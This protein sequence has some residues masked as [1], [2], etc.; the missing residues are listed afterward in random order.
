MSGFDTFP[1]V[2]TALSF[3]ISGLLL[4]W[5]LFFS[6]RWRGWFVPATLAVLFF[7]RLPS[8]V[9]NREINPDESQMITQ[10]LT[11]GQYDPV[12]FRSVDGTTGGPLDSY[13]LVLPS[14]LG[15]PFD[16]I[17][18][19]LMA[20]LLIAVCLWFLYKTAQ[21]WFGEQP[22]RL[23]LL[24]VVFTLGFTQNADFLHYNSELIAVT[25]LSAAYFLYA[26]QTTTSMPPLTRLLFA[27]GFLLGMV[28]FGKL[29][30][31]PSAAIVVMFIAYDVLTRSD[32]MIRQKTKRLV[33]LV[34]GLITFPALFLSF[35]V[36][37]G[38]F[39]DFVTFYLEGNLNYGS[40]GDPA[41]NLRNLP[42]LLGKGDEFFWLVILS[43]LISLSALIACLI[44]SLRVT[45]VIKTTPLTPP[46]TPPVFLLALTTATIFAITRTGSDYVHYLYFLLGPLLLGLAFFIKNAEKERVT[47]IPHI[48][49]IFFFA[50]LG[51]QAITRYVQFQPINRYPTDQQIGWQMPTT[52]VG[53]EIK[54]FAQ[55]GEPLAV[56]GWRCDYY[57]ETQMPQGVAENHTIRSVFTHPMVHVYQARYVRDFTR[58]MPPIFV[59]AVGNQNLWMTD[60]KTQ[61]H[62]LIKPLG[63]LV[64]QHYQFIGLF[65]DARLYVRK[66][67]LATPAIA[68]KP[69]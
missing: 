58:T 8:I 38:L 46:N 15:L 32:L 16:Y 19:H 62:E 54:K 69:V 9:Y 42:R 10:A 12:Y 28:P 63:R 2:H 27:A 35:M 31:V 21:C 18:A 24:P 6:H 22:A 68:Q 13:F 52:S 47:A 51:I 37:T 53:R 49:Y 48:I 3:L 29:Q 5:L 50:L 44:R 1:T 4:V 33:M 55:T 65:D 41:Q 34:A 56:W 45:S 59:D 39:T 23:A 17:T 26:R 60:R 20:C 61:G 7:L 25:L 40:G 30:G 14:L 57:V 11:L 36:A 43:L 66:D 64:R 67:R